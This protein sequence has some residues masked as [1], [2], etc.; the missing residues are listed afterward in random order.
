MFVNKY[1]TMAVTML[2]FEDYFSM[3]N[4]KQFMMLETSFWGLWRRP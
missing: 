1:S 4:Y 3:M 2:G